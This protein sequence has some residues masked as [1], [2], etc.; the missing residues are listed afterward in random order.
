MRPKARYYYFAFY[1]FEDTVI[2]SQVIVPIRRL[3]E[4]GWDIRL[5]FMESPFAWIRR[6]LLQRP[7]YREKLSGVPA[8]FLPRIPRNIAGM[9]T[10]L[11][12]LVFSLWGAPAPRIVVH[13]RGL[14]SAHVLLPL[15]KLSRKIRILC[16]IRGLESAEHQYTLEK[17]G[18]SGPSRWTRRLEQMEVE[19]LRAADALRC[20]SRSLW[21]YLHRR[22]GMDPKPWPG[23]PCCVDVEKFSRKISSRESGRRRLE[24]GDRLVVAYVGALNAW[25]KP[26]PLADIFRTIQAADPS[27]FF[28]AITPS[29]EPMQ[30]ALEAA[31]VHSTD[32]RVLTLPHSEVPD[33][34]AAADI[35]L[36]IRESHALNR[37]A[38]PTKFA[39]YL[40]AGLHV[41]VTD[42]VEDAASVA[43]TRE[44]GTVLSAFADKDGLSRAAWEAVRRAKDPNRIGRSLSAVQTIYDW[45]VYL[46]DLEKTYQNLGESNDAKGAER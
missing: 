22:A 9:D 43:Q 41:M 45:S 20:V 32:Y 16:D 29:V 4:K 37:F 14:Q 36:L 1:G 23:I 7:K 3:R 40:A 5:V 42:A 27:A 24:C 2:E 17:G 30:K 13:A 46:P 12:A 11:M 8:I 35:G 19:V 39:E 31:G 34:L 33:H 25:Q 44:C 18:A 38:C 21:D 6:V 28:L 10:A 26:G 15:K